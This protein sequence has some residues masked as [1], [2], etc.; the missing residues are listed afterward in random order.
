MIM[1]QIIAMQR[2]GSAESAIHGRGSGAQAFWVQHRGR[3]WCTLVTFLLSTSFVLQ[4][5]VIGV[6]VYPG[7]ESPIFS[8]ALLLDEAPRRRRLCRMLLQSSAG[9]EVRMVLLPVTGIRS[10][11]N[12]TGVD[13]REQP[14]TERRLETTHWRIMLR[15]YR[16]RRMVWTSQV[17]VSYVVC[18]VRFVSGTDGGQM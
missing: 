13:D 9:V 8:G 3:P 14:V 17:S 4:G 1:T 12:S 15:L 2:L 11:W 7:L 18:R 6:F 5:L 16:H 10:K